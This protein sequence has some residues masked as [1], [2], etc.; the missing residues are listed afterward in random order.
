MISRC[1]LELADSTV[2]DPTFEGP[3]DKAMA[4]VQQL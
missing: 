2:V 3:A 1:L 4:P